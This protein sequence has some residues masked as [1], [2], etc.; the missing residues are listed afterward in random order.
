MDD[1][2]RLTP[3]VYNLWDF[4]PLMQ[5]Y[6]F[7]ASTIGALESPV[8]FNMGSTWFYDF[9]RALR[10]AF[11]ELRIIDQQF[12]AIGHLEWNRALAD[13]IDATVAAYD[14]LATEI[15]DD[16]RISEVATVYVGIERV[17]IPGE[18]QIARFRREAGVLDDEKL[19]LFVGRLSK[20]KRPRWVTRLAPMLAEGE[21]R[22]VVVGDGPLRKDVSKGADSRELS[23]IPEV[24][25][26]EPA[27][28]AADVV[29][30]PSRVEG[31]PLV[32]LEALSLGTPIV[33]TRVGGLPDLEHEEGVTL[34]DPDDFDGF[35]EAVRKSL[36]AVFGPIELAERFSSEEMLDRYDRL[37][38]PEASAPADS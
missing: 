20:E 12:N 4:L 1:L 3:Y 22:V 7:V 30:I 29:V 14:V 32:A 11:P 25:S 35:F 36:G 23:W 38:F 34:V 33:A 17:D 21:A 5:W 6:D 10:G 26:I 19:I 37:L 13:V 18:D 28:A 16:G 8:V 27:I 15:K 9:A 2:R 31:I 24:E